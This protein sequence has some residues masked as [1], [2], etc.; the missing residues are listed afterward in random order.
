MLLNNKWIIEEI[1]RWLKTNK[2]EDTQPQI[3]VTQPKQFKEWNSLTI[4]AYLIKKISND[5]CNPKPKGT[6]ERITNKAQSE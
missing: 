3:Y 6:R 2:N 1:K 5:Q 4:Q